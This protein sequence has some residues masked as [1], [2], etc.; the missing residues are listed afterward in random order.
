MT[1]LT[2][3]ALL[4][5]AAITAIAGATQARA[6]RNDYT[7]NYCQYYQQKAL[8]TGERYWWDR[9]RACLNGDW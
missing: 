1:R 4:A 9:Y 8:Y 6:G 2:A 3:L 7:W 5:A